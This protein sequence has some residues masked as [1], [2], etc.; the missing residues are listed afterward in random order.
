MTN[1]PISKS[2]REESGGPGCQPVLGEWR[3]YVGNRF[4]GIVVSP[5]EKYPSMFRIYR[6]GQ[7]P[8]DM[9][10]LTRA[11]DAASATARI[12]GREV[13][14]WKYREIGSGEHRAR[15]LDGVPPTRQTTSPPV[16]NDPEP[17]LVP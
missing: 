10:N 15:L 14:Y 3:L 4:T 2:E 5:D 8:S 17:A 1:A 11:K 7:P 16:S 9:V 13:F 6:P 12:G